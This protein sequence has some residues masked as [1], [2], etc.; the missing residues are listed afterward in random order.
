MD[1]YMLKLACDVEIYVQAEQ[2]YTK[3]TFQV[4]AVLVAILSGILTVSSQEKK[5]VQE[6][7]DCGWDAQS[8]FAGSPHQFQS[9]MRQWCPVPILH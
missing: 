4:Y 8:E 6:R 1:R 5:V 9:W 2:L 3:F 7:Q